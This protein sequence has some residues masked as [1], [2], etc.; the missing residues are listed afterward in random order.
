MILVSETMSVHDKI[1]TFG[2]C[3][4]YLSSKTNHNKPIKS[5]HAHNLYRPALD[6]AGKLGCACVTQPRVEAVAVEVV[7]D[8]GRLGR[9]SAERHRPPVGASSAAVH[10]RA[11]G[12]LRRRSV[13]TGWYD[14]IRTANYR[15]T[16]QVSDNILLILIWEFHHVAYMP[17]QFCHICNCPNRKRQTSELPNQSRQNVVANLTGHPV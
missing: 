4:K 2:E 10:P 16:H 9:P 17:C 11:H 7:V 13:H 8:H 6:H 14:K 12:G 15:V 5:V 3:R 1:I